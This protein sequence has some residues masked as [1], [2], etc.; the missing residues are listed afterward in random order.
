M[1]EVFNGSIMINAHLQYIYTH[2]LLKQTI[3]LY[4][5]HAHIWYIIKSNTSERH[6]TIAHISPPV[7]YYVQDSNWCTMS[8]STRIVALTLYQDHIP[9]EHQH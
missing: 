9:P 5:T 4:S 7:V 1:A 6:A 2:R 8:H 3:N